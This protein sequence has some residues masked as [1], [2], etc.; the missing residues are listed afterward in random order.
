MHTCLN[1]IQLSREIYYTFLI[2]NLII[3]IFKYCFGNCFKAALKTNLKRDS[4]S[5]STAKSTVISSPWFFNENNT[6]RS[7]RAQPVWQKLC[8]SIYRKRLHLSSD[9]SSCSCTKVFSSFYINPSAK[10]T[11]PAS[12]SK[13]YSELC[14]HKMLANKASSH[15]SCQVK[16]KPS[17]VSM[18][19]F[20]I[21]TSLPAAPNGTALNNILSTKFLLPQ[22]S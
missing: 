4:R 1:F 13:T 12:P 6:Y 3:F 15:H 7:Q 21:Q 19:K 11:S 5:Q 2:E 16:G 8:L 22:R 20:I 9:I 18:P 14:S 17:R 10:G